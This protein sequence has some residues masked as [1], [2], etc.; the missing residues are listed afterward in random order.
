MR[1]RYTALRGLARTR[2]PF[3]T[4][5]REQLLL[6]VF[7]MYVCVCMFEARMWLAI[8]TCKRK[9]KSVFPVRN[10]ACTE[11]QDQGKRCY[12]AVDARDAI[13][14]FYVSAR[15]AGIVI[16]VHLFRTRAWSGFFCEDCPLLFRNQNVGT[17]EL[18]LKVHVSRTCEATSR[19]TLCRL[20]ET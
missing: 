10:H 11:R 16:G 17:Q 14:H 6:P 12:V 15:S 19:G 13:M 20:R 3:S 18:K 1:L 7:Y 9:Q 5:M 4:Q 2:S 8:P